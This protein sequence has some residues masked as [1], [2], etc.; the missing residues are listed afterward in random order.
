MTFVSEVMSAATVKTGRAFAFKRE[1][2]TRRNKS[3]IVV[4]A[5]LTW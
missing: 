2:F 1:S 4:N 5:K 3:N